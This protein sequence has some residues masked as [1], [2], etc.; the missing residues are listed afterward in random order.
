MTFRRRNSAEENEPHRH[1]WDWKGNCYLC[2]KNRKKYFE[3]LARDEKAEIKKL[4][5]GKR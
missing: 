4:K 2:G 3:E 1:D 5:K